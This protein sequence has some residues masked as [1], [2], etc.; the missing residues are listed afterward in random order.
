MNKTRRQ[1]D[2]CNICSR[3]VKVRKGLEVENLNQ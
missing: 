2:E 3:D 1:V